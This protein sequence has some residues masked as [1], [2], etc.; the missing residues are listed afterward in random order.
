MFLQILTNDRLI[1]LKCPAGLRYDNKRA[2]R[3]EVNV[4]VLR[5]LYF[6]KITKNVDR[7]LLI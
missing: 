1:P 6:D 4:Y 2:L 5:W 3:T 7:I